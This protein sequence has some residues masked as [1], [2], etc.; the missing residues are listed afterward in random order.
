MSS[1]RKRG[2]DEYMPRNDTH[3]SLPDGSREGTGNAPDFL[4]QTLEFWQPRTKRKLTREDARE[5][6]ENLTG[7]FRVLMEWAR[8]DRESAN[9][10]PNDTKP[11][12]SKV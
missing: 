11:P 1:I 7:F 9:A 2:R 5:I 3:S 12:P 6:N 10:A 4:D 8:I